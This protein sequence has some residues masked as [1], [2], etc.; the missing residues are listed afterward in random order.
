[1][2]NYHGRKAALLAVSGALALVLSGCGGGDDGPGS[3]A[4]ANPSSTAGVKKGGS[5][6]LLSV[7]DA[8]RFNPFHTT[9]AAVTDLNRMLALYDTLFYTDNANNKIV[10]NIG[11]SLATADGGTTWTMK[12]KPN[13]KFSDGTG[14][15]AEAVKK[16]WDM[17]ANPETRSYHV[18]AAASL[19]SEVVDPLTL[20]ITPVAPNANLDRLIALELSYIAAPASLADT[21]GEKP[22]GAGPFVLKEWTRGN[23]MVFE[24]NPN[25]WQGPDKPALDRLVIKVVPD[26]AQQLS[27]VKSNGADV[28]FTID[29]EKTA[30]AKKEGLGITPFTLDG[31]QMVAFNSKV[32]PFDD[33]RA[34]KAVALAL[35]PAD[36]NERVFSGTAVPAKSIFNSKDRFFDPSAVQP[37]TNRAAAQELFNQLA[38]EGKKVDF[39]YMVPENPASN[40][41]AEYTM[42]A[43]N[44]YENVSVKLE[45]VD[46]KQYTNKLQIGRNYQA[47]LY[48]VWASDVEPILYKFLHSK[49]PEN[50]LHYANADV[51][52][53]LDTG[54]A[55]AD[56]AQRKAAYAALQKAVVTDFPV[57]AYQEAVTVIVSGPKV[58]G[59]VGVQD[60]GMLMD[61]VGVSG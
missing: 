16:N 55:T 32:P 12:L 45:K 6:T 38:A 50:F 29:P 56:E 11:E 42:T 53:A 44:G 60:G 19:K 8:Q 34:R 61:R 39:T 10:P 49:S 22:V 21:T 20:K 40:R 54:R 15:D 27:T 37:S 48:Q 35:D 18:S 7:S 33:P 13:V 36:L 59:I 25:Y 43:L 46:V 41:T 17:H 14:L 28:F 23:Q 58:S 47:A 57:V 2:R 1:M 3:G 51:D 24:K 26:V 4:S 52:K 31:G 5:L 9:Y 30:N